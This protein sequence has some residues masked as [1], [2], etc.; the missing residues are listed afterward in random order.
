M[1]EAAGI[2]REVLRNEP[3][4]IAA[5]H[6]LGVIH[7]QLG[8]FT[9]A[10]RAFSD[11]VKL[12]PNSPELL[13]NRGNARFEL[14]RFSDALADYDAALEREPSRAMLWNNR[15]NALLALVRREDAIASFTRAIELG[16][17]YVDALAGRADA[18]SALG[19]EHDALR[20]IEQALAIS[21]SA[22][23]Y[24]QRGILLLRRKNAEAAL[25]DFNKA[26][27]AEPRDVNCHIARAMALVALKQNESALAALDNALRLDTANVQ[28]L[29]NRASVLTRLKFY[30]EAL[31]S[32]DRALKLQPD[33]A[34]A[35]HN[36]GAALAGLKR[37]KDAL[38]AYERALALDAQNAQ[39]WSNAGAAMILLDRN[40][41]ALGYL[42]RAL[43]LNAGDPEIWSNRGKALATLNRFPEALGDCAKAIA[44]APDHVPALRIAIHARL[45]S[46]DWS[47][48]D[49]DISQI[50]SGLREGRRMIDPL[51]CLA[52]FDS[53]AENLAAAKLW[54]EEECP[55][56]SGS[57]AEMPRYSHDRLRIAYLS[58]DL[59]AHAVGFLI[60]GVFEHHDKSRFEITALSCGPDDRS[61][62]RL[63]MQAA[64]DRFIDIRDMTDS[65]VA[66]LIREM[67]IDI[68]VDLNG[69]TGSMRTAIVAFHAA[70][71]QVNFLGYPGT[72]AASY[73]DYII[74]DPTVI[75]ESQRSFYTERTVYLPDCYQPNDR[76]RSVAPS[77]HS[78][79]EAGLP[80]S[81]FV[82]CCFNNN[83]KIG[84]EIFDIW[85]RL[86]NATPGSVLWLLQDNSSAAAN[87]RREAVARG[88]SADR[89]I[90]APRTNP[91]AHLARHSLADLFLD[92]L[93]YNAHT[94]ASDSVWT[95]LPLITCPGTTFQSRVAASILAA[96][97]M[98]ELIAD[99]LSDYEALALKLS[100]DR[101]LMS[102]IRAK[103]AV[104][105]ETCTLF[106]IAR[107][108]RNLES[109][110]VQIATA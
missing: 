9:E 20:D 79:E 16:P 85:M 28:A 10:E 58:T 98:Q 77:V 100:R 74:A 102:R 19:R 37:V 99:S 47:R 49:Q 55:P 21:P 46:C 90:F 34:G 17:A 78:R 41:A 81:A 13:L 70:P 11:A 53:G 48:R 82:F 110:Y 91:A 108:T 93:P 109:A 57:L 107:F 75:P 95:G 33:S 94:T 32:A 2:C 72:M 43:E 50:T 25:R 69:Y 89:L 97:G 80:T 36:R 76:R 88:V 44:L 61:T 27:A 66:K 60:A 1:A 68:L 6:M 54:M 23:L 40:E 12:A 3:R 30:E 104:N 8:Q 73:V 92:T 103:L 31:L 87:L 29:S 26:I 7:A 59:R 64:F 45:R 83:Y 96:A 35:W 105:R 24:Y 71:R 18:Y 14:Q 5:F 101:E 106:D 22:E 84:P 15:G 62:T 63:R 39:T 51:H 42:E 65:D 38:S 56:Q 86:L 67:E 4:Q 52:M